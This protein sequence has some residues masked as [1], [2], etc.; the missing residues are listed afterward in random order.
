MSTS[1]G[2]TLPAWLMR[3]ATCLP[4]EKYEAMAKCPERPVNCLF[5][6]GCDGC[7]CGT[8]GAVLS[9]SRAACS[10][11][12]RFSRADALAVPCARTGD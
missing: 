1:R 6:P 11:V 9:G 2:A 8:N 4:H 12:G 7:A 5:A 3:N 10:H